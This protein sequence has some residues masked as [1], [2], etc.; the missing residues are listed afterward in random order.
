MNESKEL[1]VLKENK[2]VTLYRSALI[3][4]YDPD[5]TV[6]YFSHT[7]FENLNA[8]PYTFTNKRNETL[9]G[10]FY[11]YGE[12]QSDRLIVFDHGLGAGHTAYMKEIERLARAGYTVFSY[13]KSGCVKSEGESIHAF[14]QSISDLDDAIT[15]LKASPM[16]EKAKISVVGH[17]WGGYATLNIPAFHPDLVSIVSLSAPISAKAM[18]QSFFPGLLSLLIPTVMR[19]ERSANP[20]FADC[21]ALHTLRQYSGKALVIHSDDDATVKPQKHFNRLQNALRDRENLTFLSVS[22]KNHNP[23]YTA[24]AV[25][26]LAEF[27]SALTEKNRAHAFTSDEDRRAFRDS[28]DFDKMTEQDEALWQTV[29]EFLD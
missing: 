23:N 11:Y 2:I 1:T 24:D 28:F 5:P 18:L 14:S 29:L 21:S 3:R 7:D 26:R 15:S 10:A 6:F 20:D 12:R 27:S 25:R 16:G 8:K 19:F 13:D 4:R 17:S 22:G 9:V